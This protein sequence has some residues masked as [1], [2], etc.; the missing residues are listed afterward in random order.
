MKFSPQKFTCLKKY[1]GEI[2]EGDLIET[3]KKVNKYFDDYNN[4]AFSSSNNNEQNKILKVNVIENK[5][6][7]EFDNSIF[8]RGK[9]QVNNNFINLMGKYGN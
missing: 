8:N 9:N 6:N 7:N 5:N 3:E 4:F 2:I 1:F